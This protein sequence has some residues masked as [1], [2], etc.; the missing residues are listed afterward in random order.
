LL[1]RARYLGIVVLARWVPSERNV[2]HRIAY[3]EQQR[4]KQG[5]WISIDNQWELPIEFRD[6]LRPVYD[7]Q[8]SRERLY[9]ELPEYVC[10][11][12][13]KLL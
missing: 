7:N 11:F 8:C 3:K 12:V 9:T 10:D 1:V 13:N 4:R 2:A 5:N 6:V